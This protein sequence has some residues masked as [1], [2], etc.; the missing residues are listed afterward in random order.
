[1]A[2]AA[3][4]LGSD[5]D[6]RIVENDGKELGRKKRWRERKEGVILTHTATSRAG[7]TNKAIEGELAG[8]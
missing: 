4:K 8:V 7:T 2:N 3:V 6:E 1:M 5:G